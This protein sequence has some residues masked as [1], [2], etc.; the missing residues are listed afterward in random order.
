M[1]VTDDWVIDTYGKD[2]AGKLMDRAEHQEFI[3]PLNEDGVFASIKLDQRN[4]C[5][6]KY[7]PE[8]YVHMT[9]DKGI[10][11][12]TEEVCVKT[13]WKGLLDDGT[14]TDLNEGVV[15]QFGQWFVNECKTL[16]SQKCVA[17]PVGLW[18]YLVMEICPGLRCD[19]APPVKFMHD[20]NDSFF[21]VPLLWLFIK[22]VFL[23]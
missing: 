1:S 17:I 3:E 20:E 16:A 8:K 9:N 21:S 23:I 13:M 11:H 22:P 6:V 7:F 2:I 10:E 18:R 15:S 12:V 5:R 4:I 14:I 19:N